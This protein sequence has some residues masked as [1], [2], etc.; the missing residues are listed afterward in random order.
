MNI[1]FSKSC[2]GFAHIKSGKP[3]QDYSLSYQDPERTILACCD[4]HGGDVYVR[5]ARGS[6]FAAN[7]VLNVF[8]SLSPRFLAKHR[9]EEAEAKIKME[10]LC[11]W[12]RLAEEDLQRH[13]LSKRELECLDEAKKE[14]LL[15]NPI[16][17]YGTTM[18]GAL[19]LGNWLV[20]ASIGDSE[21]I[22]LSKGTMEC[23]LASEDDPAGNI[24]YSLCQDDAYRHIRVKVLPFRG[25]AGVFLMT[26]G[27]A[28]PYQSYANL[29]ASF[30]KPLAKRAALEGSSSFAGDLVQELAERRGSGDDVSLAFLLK[31]KRS[32]EIRRRR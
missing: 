24:T 25:I 4:G 10:L 2:R 22:L 18:T 9:G 26:A 31:G 11:E 13:A 23:P 15:A 29:E 28:G 14:S 5:S 21:C 3:C 17:A 27:F 6:K 7:A 20:I 8:S 19:L 1:V 16:K 32:H 12:N 30:L